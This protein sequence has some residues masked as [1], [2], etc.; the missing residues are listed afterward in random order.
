LKPLKYKKTLV[1]YTSMEATV[2][3]HFQRRSEIAGNNVV[4]S[5]KH[6]TKTTRLK[7]RQVFALL[8][9]STRFESV[10]A[11]EI[12]YWGDRFH[13]FRLSDSQ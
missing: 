3:E 2:V 7:Q 13:F 10:K 11:D 5:C 8:N 9:K 4:L 12:G 1:I 6:I